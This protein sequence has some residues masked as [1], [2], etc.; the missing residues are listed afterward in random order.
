ML[1]PEKNGFFK[2]AIGDYRA[3]VEK[4]NDKKL[5][6]ELHECLK[7]EKYDKEATELMN[8]QRVTVAI[9]YQSDFE[10][11]PRLDRRQNST[12]RMLGENGMCWE[13]FS[14]WFLLILIWIFMGNLV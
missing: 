4:E 2:L 10:D 11:C 8:E 7:V 12:N 13:G 14:F 1:N 5:V 6:A 9:T 3:A